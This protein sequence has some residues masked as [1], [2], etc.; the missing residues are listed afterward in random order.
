MWGL[1]MSDGLIHFNEQEFDR[2][3]NGEIL[4]KTTVDGGTTVHVRLVVP[5]GV[6]HN[7]VM[8]RARQLGFQGQKDQ[9][10]DSPP[11]AASVPPPI[12]GGNPAVTVPIAAPAA[13]GGLPLAAGI[14]AIANVTGEGA[15]V[16]TL[17]PDAASALPGPPPV[18][19]PSTVAAGAP[20]VAFNGG[21]VED[22]GER[23]W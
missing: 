7:R 23:L 8:E 21:V 14:P 3:K 2:L 16:R 20:P 13:P 6:S 1:R 10:G 15:P 9:G 11:K 22:I 18:N 12:P 5:T 17:S 19:A 4:E